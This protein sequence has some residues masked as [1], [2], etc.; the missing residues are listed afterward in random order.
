MYTKTM[1]IRRQE[2]DLMIKRERT[3]LQSAAVFVV[4]KIRIVRQP[5]RIEYTNSKK[6]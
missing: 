2:N 6:I 3:Q 1:I 5:K 4:H